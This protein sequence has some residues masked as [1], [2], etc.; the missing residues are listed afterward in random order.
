MRVGYLYVSAVLF[1]SI[2][3]LEAS[4]KYCL[5]SLGIIMFAMGLQLGLHGLCNPP[6]SLLEQLSVVRAAHWMCTRLQIM[7]QGILSLQSTKKA[8]DAWGTTPKDWRKIHV[9][10]R[11][12]HRAKSALRPDSKIINLNAIIN[13]PSN[14][15]IPYF[16][17]KYH[18]GSVILSDWH[19]LFYC[20]LVYI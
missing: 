5:L 7:M 11:C 8:S 12:L 3:L 18:S 2:G 9:H 13:G 17:I 6:S 15:S 20:C 1:F 4:L 16:R 19:L 14:N 10:W